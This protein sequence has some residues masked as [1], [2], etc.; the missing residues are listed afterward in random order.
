MRPEKVCRKHT[1]PLTSTGRL[2]FAPN[3]AAVL[4]TS[5]AS[6][7]TISTAADIFTLRLTREFPPLLQSFEPA[8]LFVE[9]EELEAPA[10]PAVGKP[11]SSWLLSLPPPCTSLQHVVDVMEAA[12]ILMKLDCENEV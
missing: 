11:S 1:L 10:A 12:V 2:L 9:A 4:N 3:C 7:S 8:D 5:R 6:I